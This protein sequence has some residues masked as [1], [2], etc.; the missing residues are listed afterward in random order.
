M[1]VQPGRRSE[2]VGVAGEAQM[3]PRSD[4][5]V[6]LCG[7]KMFE[8]GRHIVVDA[9]AG[10]IVDPDQFFVVGQAA[11]I[12]ADVHARIERGQPPRFG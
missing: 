1:P 7:R 3:R 11:Q 5:R 9:M 8:Q 6:D 10:K 4:Q 2:A 12:E